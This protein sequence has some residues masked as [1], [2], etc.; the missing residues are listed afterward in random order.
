MAEDRFTELL[1]KKLANE[2]TPEELNEFKT[3][4]AIN[5]HYRREYET[6]Y[7]FWKQKEQPYKNAT[8]VFENIKSRTDIPQRE[9][10]LIVPLWQVKPKPQWKRYSAA[11]VL[12]LAVAV[13]AVKFLR[14]ASHP[15]ASTL[16]LK[17]FQTP[18]RIISKLT[19][20][21]GT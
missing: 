19:L 5:V 21:D 4:L 18:D 11:A 17:Q 1:A 14:N 16:S 12:V 15:D 20:S 9:E 3:L 8:A 6:L 10:A 13:L 7:D 2:I